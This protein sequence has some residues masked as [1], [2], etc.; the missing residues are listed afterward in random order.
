M[1]VG[2]DLTVN[3][4]NDD[5]VK[6]ENGYGPYD[7]AGAPRQIGIVDLGAYEADEH[8]AREIPSIIV[9]TLDDV[10]NPYDGLIS[11]REA[12]EVY[13]HYR[14]NAD[15][16]IDVNARLFDGERDP[17]GLTVTFDFSETYDSLINSK[18][19]FNVNSL[20]DDDFVIDFA[21]QYKNDPITV[22]DSMTIDA[23]K[24]KLGEKTVAYE[25]VPET[26]TKTVDVVVTKRYADNPFEFVS[27][28]LYQREFEVPVYEN[29]KLVG[30]LVATELAEPEAIFAPEGLCVTVDANYQARVFQIDERA[31]SYA[32]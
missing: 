10:V 32:Q 11:L 14:E 26:E 7:L 25:F 2:N 3:V 13:F 27:R 24:I 4:G 19:G 6:E 22:K 30:E 18:D 12:V 1:L 29:G 31:E 16:S 23:S 5:F 17:N 21:E 15:G 9:T 28:E 20:T 8:A